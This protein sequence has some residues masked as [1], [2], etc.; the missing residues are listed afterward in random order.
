MWSLIAQRQSPA[1]R[2]NS[3]ASCAFDLLRDCRSAEPLA[4]RPRARSSIDIIL[5]W[6]MVRS[7]ADGLSPACAGKSNNF[8]LVKVTRA[9]RTMFEGT[10]SG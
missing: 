9:P 4:L 8:Y 3:L 2:D 1:P 7:K 6:F 10:S 5:A